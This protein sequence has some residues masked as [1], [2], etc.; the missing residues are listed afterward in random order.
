MRAVS[1]P[2]VTATATG[3]GAISPSSQT[4]S[5]GATATLNFQT[6]GF[7]QGQPTCGVDLSTVASACGGGGS[8]STYVPGAPALCGVGTYT[9]GPITADCSVTVSFACP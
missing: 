1:V 5:A 7:Y 8:C 6:N 2:V 4:V 3:F 9:T